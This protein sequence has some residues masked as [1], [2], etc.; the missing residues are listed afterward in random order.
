[1]V[2]ILNKVIDDF[3]NFDLSK[4]NYYNELNIMI[5]F[6]RTLIITNMIESK[7]SLKL[8]KR[9]E[10][11]VGDYVEGNLSFECLLNDNIIFFDRITEKIKGDKN[12]V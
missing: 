10:N 2:E 3:E 4:I 1:M 8:I 11:I 5:S 6:I 9:I 12:N 7:D